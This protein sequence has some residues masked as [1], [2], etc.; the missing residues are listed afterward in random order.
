ID[1]RLAPDA[2]TEYLL[3]QGAVGV[4]PQSGGAAH[5]GAVRERIRAYMREG[6]REAAVHTSWLAPATQWEDALDRFVDAVFDSA[7]FRADMDALVAS[8]GRAGLWNALARTLVHL[9][10]P[11]V[12]D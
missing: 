1:G 8:I 9:T 6:T 4:W 10:A 3:Y 7:P 11:G 2:V 12:P 5:L